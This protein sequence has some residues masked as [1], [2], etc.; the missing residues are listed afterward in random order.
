MRLRLVTVG[1]LFGVLASAAVVDRIVIIVNS[2]L[3]K[4]SDISRDLLATQMLNGEAPDTSIG[5]KKEECNTFDL[6]RFL[7]GTK[8]TSVIIPSPRKKKPVAS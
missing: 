2:D 7:F 6:I 1:L 3:I 8:S 5:A 4:D